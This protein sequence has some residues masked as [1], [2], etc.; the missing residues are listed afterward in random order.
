MATPQSGILADVPSFSRYLEFGAVADTDPAPVLR[1]LASQDFGEDVVIGLGIA[2]V[3]SL[4]A[5][6]D[7]LRPFPSLAGPGAEV[8]ST[9]GPTSGFG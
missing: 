9:Q 6:I 3:Q 7:G 8:P 1:G 4:G 5:T 2:L